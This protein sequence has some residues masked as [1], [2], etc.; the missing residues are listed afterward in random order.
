MRI[1]SFEFK[2]AL[3]PTVAA[4]VLVPFLSGMGV[5]QLSRAAE[6]EQR[7][8]EYGQRNQAGIVNVD[9]NNVFDTVSGYR[10]VR[11]SG[12]YDSEHAFLLDNQVHN[13]VV[14]YHVF[15]PLRLGDN[16]LILVNRGWIPQ[17]V[18]RDVLPVF[19]TPETEVT[20]LGVLSPA[21]GHGMLLGDDIQSNVIWPRVVQAVI[22]PR[23]R[24]ELNF[25]L[26][27]QILLLDPAEADGFMREWKIVQFGPEKN[28]GYA[29]QWFMMAVAVLIIFIVVNTRR[30]NRVAEAGE[31]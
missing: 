16:R 17:G 22:L 3:W 12:Q 23:L 5:W 7:L 21:P 9:A 11:I 19:S 1:A 15:S 4:L 29:F 28:L 14:G 31:S 26:A 24:L 10:Q 30:I 2:P 25:E 20:I 18:S 13:G 8:Q 6:K 27:P